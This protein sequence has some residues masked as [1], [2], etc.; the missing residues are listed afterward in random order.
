MATGDREN[1]SRLGADRIC[2]P[3]AGTSRMYEIESRE[4][5]CPG[6]PADRGLAMRVRKQRATL[7]E[8]IDVGRLESVCAV[9]GQVSVTQ[10]VGHY[11]NDVGFVGG[12]KLEAEQEARE[13]GK[14]AAE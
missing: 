2:R 5:R 8:L 3:A 12:G 4:E 11:D 6:W 10:V 9:A 1:A 7:G 13:Q 14:C